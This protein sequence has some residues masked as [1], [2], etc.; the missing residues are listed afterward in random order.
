ML[1]D[2]LVDAST[3]QDSRN[4]SCESSDIDVYIHE[5]WSFLYSSE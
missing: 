3:C 2:W 4:R 5:E 1:G